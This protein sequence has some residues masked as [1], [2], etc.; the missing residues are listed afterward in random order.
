[1][2]EMRLIARPRVNDIARG[3]V[4][5]SSTTEDDWTGDRAADPPLAALVD[6]SRFQAINRLVERSFPRFD[7]PRKIRF[8]REA[9]NGKCR[10][11]GRKRRNVTA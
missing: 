7:S 1:M 8:I 5:S 3:V 10:K 9:V 4:L 2:A 6:D 11:L